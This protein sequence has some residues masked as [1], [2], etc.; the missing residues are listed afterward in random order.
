MVYF[1]QMDTDHHAYPPP[2]PQMTATRRERP[3]EVCGSSYASNGRMNGKLPVSTIISCKQCEVPF[4]ERV[5]AR[6]HSRSV[7]KCGICHSPA[8]QFIRGAEKLASCMA[9]GKT[10]SSNIS[11]LALHALLSSQKGL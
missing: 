4:L 10:K 7:T 6:N 11:A 8:E 5:P 3:P 9:Q 2:T 1:L